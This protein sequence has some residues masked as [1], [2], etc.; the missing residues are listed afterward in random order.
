MAHYFPWRNWFER[1]RLPR[2]LA[3]AAGLLAILLPATVAAMLA[4]STVAQA[5]GLLWLAAGS[6]AVGTLV[7]W[8][9]DWQKRNEYRH[10]DQLERDSL[11]G[12]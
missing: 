11:Y 12:E 3:Y 2:L 4:A 5:L 8:W 9:H 1:A 6:A 10:A 7:P